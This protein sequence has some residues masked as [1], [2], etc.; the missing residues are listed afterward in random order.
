MAKQMMTPPKDAIACIEGLKPHATRL[1]PTGA[2]RLD[3]IAEEVPVAL[4]YNGVSHA[5][6]M[7]SPVDLMSFALGFSYTEGIISHADELYDTEVQ[8]GA[9]GISINLTISQRCFTK[10]KARNRKLTG[11]SGCG[12]CGIESLK[13]LSRDLPAINSQVTISSQSIQ[14]AVKNFSPQQQLRAETG[15]THA[16]AWCNRNGDILTIAEDV[17]RH[18]ALDKLIGKLLRQKDIPE[19]FILTSSRVSFEMVQKAL[20]L[21]APLLVGVSAPT[22]IALSEAEAKGLCIVAFAR[23]GRHVVYTHQERIL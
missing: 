11:P 21:Q 18:N 2:T 4:V 9:H 22:T 7:A 20:A 10:L 6:M 23:P 12:L 1:W 5:V 8:Q 13:M 19:G 16:S 14:T 17:G 3:A 15:G